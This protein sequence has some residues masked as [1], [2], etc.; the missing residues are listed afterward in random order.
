MERESIKTKLLSDGN[1]IDNLFMIKDETLEI[2]LI[3]LKQLSPRILNTALLGLKVK[4][5]AYCH[6]QDN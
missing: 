2:E 3:K 5:N 4:L 1:L 6:N